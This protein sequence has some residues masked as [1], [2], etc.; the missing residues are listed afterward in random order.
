MSSATPSHL[1][2]FSPTH[3]AMA[4]SCP[5]FP[6]LPSEI[7]LRIWQLHLHRE[8]LL[9]IEVASPASSDL[10]QT[11]VSVLSFNPISKFFRVNCKSINSALGFYRVHVP[12]V[13]QWNQRRRSTLYVN[14]EFDTSWIQGD[15]GCGFGL[16]NF[17]YDLQASDPPRIGLARQAI[18]LQTARFLG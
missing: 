5:Q 16:A 3:E 9:R 4:G 1:E 18:D 2:I 8:R 17:L 10:R 15:L 12:C 11:H 7:C 6:R 14:L 13:Y